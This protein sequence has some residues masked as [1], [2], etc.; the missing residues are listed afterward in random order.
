MP[1]EADFDVLVIGRGLLASAGARHLTKENIKVGLLGP[2]EQQCLKSGR[3]FASHFDNTRVQRT[4]GQDEIWTRLN[5][6]SVKSWTELQNET[7]ISFFQE[8]G[9]I[10]LN[11]RTDEY[12][13]AAPALADQFN[14]SFET[15]ENNAAL[16]QI[17]DY[18]Q[19]SENVTGLFESKSAGWINPKKLVSAQL[20]SFKSFG[21]IEINDYAVDISRSGDSWL[22]RTSSGQELSATRVLVAAG[23][24]SNYFNLLPRQLDFQ[25]KSEVVIMAKLSV[26][27]FLKMKDMPS[28]LFE[29]KVEEFDG[30]YL[31]APTQVE[32]GS[33]IMK[34]GLNQKIDR[35]INDQAAMEDW[36]ALGDYRD[37]APVLERELRKLFPEIEFLETHLKPCVISRTATENPY[38]GEVDSGLFVLLGCNG[39][40]A[41][42]SDAQGRQAAALITRGRFDDG[43]MESD[44]KLVYR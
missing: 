8:N 9:C 42:S 14:L 6:D 16:N 27:D 1:V 20:Q 34:M 13:N 29:K 11:T 10:Y 5:R 44:F 31:T 41:M 28:L 4:L 38:I 17:S 23:S 33:Y 26:E 19:I 2:T 22:I 21:G 32:D 36:F 25:N 3:V 40:S 35:D 43:Y 39:Y 12:L 15:I 7:G 18:F 37:F 30:I 24:F